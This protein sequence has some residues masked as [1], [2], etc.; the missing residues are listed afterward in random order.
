MKLQQPLGDAAEKVLMPPVCF[1]WTMR[2]SDA[3]A[4]NAHATPPRFINPR[5][6]RCRAFQVKTRGAGVDSS[7]MA[8]SVSLT[9]VAKT[10]IRDRTSIS[11][12]HN[13]SFT[14]TPGEFV[15]LLGPSGCG[16]STVLRLIGGLE[17]P[18]SG[19][20]KIGS[21]AVTSTD[22]RTAVVFQEPRL[23][24]WRTVAGNIALGTNRRRGNDSRLSRTQS[25]TLGRH[26]LDQVGLLDTAS[27]FPHQ[28]SGG[29]AQRV[30]LARGLAC[31]PEVLLLDEP[32][33][34][35]DAL[36]R[37][38]M[39]ELLAKIWTDRKSTV[40]LV[41]HDVDEAL[42]LADRI[43]ILGGTP[44]TIVDS[45]NIPAQRPRDRND[46]AFL[47]LRARILA[48]FGLAYEQ[49]SSPDFEWEAAD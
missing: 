36:T 11:V 48:H 32:F 38:R 15:V 4:A 31:E 45:I 44:A 17:T 29:M 19:S 22:D 30:A 39:Q 41:T 43:I 5:S 1:C 24:P 28:L 21:E 10:F 2:G 46:P 20:V 14:T 42:Y 25:R 35:L 12:L 27:A 34:A 16:K 37:M 49:A 7:F 23:L 8:S 33:A 47:P 13:L 18:S 26:L 3:I 9:Q 6:R 40:V